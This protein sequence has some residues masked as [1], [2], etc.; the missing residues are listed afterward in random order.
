MNICTTQ[1]MHFIK[2]QNLNMLLPSAW[3]KLNDTQGKII[4]DFITHYTHSL[5]PQST[6]D[7]RKQ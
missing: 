5:L 3:V 7:V 2:K 1:T 4:Y 6:D